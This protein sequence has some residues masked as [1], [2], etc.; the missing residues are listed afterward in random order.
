[1]DDSI[2]LTSHFSLAVFMNMKPAD[3]LTRYVAPTALGNLASLTIRTESGTDEYVITRTEQV[4]EN[5]EL[6]YDQD[7][8]VVYDVACTRNGADVAY[9]SLEAAYND[10]LVVTV[11]GALPAGWQTDA[12][13]HTAY[14]FTQTDGT[15]HTV[16][17]VQYDAFH[18]AVVLDGNAMF[19][20]IRGG[21]DL[22]ME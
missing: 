1:M 22:Q 9:S 6:V 18:D 19:Y 12:D 15:V 14:T 16:E 3:T 5:N 4:A 8:N 11:S 20:L 13:A 7:G 17:L 2:Y 10:L 21:M